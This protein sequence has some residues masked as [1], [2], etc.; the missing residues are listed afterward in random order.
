MVP[1]QNSPEVKVT[2]T[3]LAIKMTFRSFS[4]MGVPVREIATAHVL[5]HPLAERGLCG[6]TSALVYPGYPAAWYTPMALRFSASL[7]LAAW[8]KA[9]QHSQQGPGT[10]GQPPSVP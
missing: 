2:F 3:T 6:L 4:A 9:A 10:S 5:T 8:L 1:V 7:R